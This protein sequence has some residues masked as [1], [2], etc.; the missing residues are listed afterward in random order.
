[1][2]FNKNIHTKHKMMDVISLMTFPRLSLTLFTMF[3]PDFPDP[4]LMKMDFPYFSFPDWRHLQCIVTHKK[5]EEQETYCSY[6]VIPPS[7]T[8][9]Q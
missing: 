7:N 6:R 4:F 9:S 1:M 8:Q 3:S 2:H 5:E